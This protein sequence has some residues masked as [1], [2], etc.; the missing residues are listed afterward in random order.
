MNFFY[1]TG[2]CSNVSMNLLV[3]SGS[4]QEFYTVETRSL[5]DVFF[6][7]DIANLERLGPLVKLAW[8]RHEGYETEV[9]SPG[10]DV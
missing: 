6:W 5:F 7:A 10:C 8:L 1:Y 4:V 9:Q 2:H 3:S